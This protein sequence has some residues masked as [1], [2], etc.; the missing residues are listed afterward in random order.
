VILSEL[1][2]LVPG[3]KNWELEEVGNG[4]YKVI[5]PTKS[6]MARLRK[7]KYLEVDSE[8]KMFFEEWSS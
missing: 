1:D 7:V 4:V 8:R 5:L 3:N 2:V 6:D